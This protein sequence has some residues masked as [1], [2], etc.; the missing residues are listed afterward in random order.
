MTLQLTTMIRRKEDAQQFLA[1][2]VSSDAQFDQ[3]PTNASTSDIPQYT[4]E[5]EICTTSKIGCYCGNISDSS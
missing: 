3:H 5:T 2:V 1:T 4:L